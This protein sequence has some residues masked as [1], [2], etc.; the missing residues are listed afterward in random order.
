MNYRGPGFLAVVRSGSS[1]TPTPFSSATCLCFSVFLCVASRAYWRNKGGGRGVKSYDCE[2]AWSSIH[3]STLNTFH[4][5]AF[6]QLFYVSLANVIRLDS[7]FNRREA[8]CLSIWLSVCLSCMSVWPTDRALHY[9]FLSTG[10][11][12]AFFEVSRPAGG[13]KEMSSTV[14]WL[15]NS[16]QMR[17]MGAGSQP[18]NTAVHMEPK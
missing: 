16:A 4:P 8:G 5:S 11:I 10:A 7:H 12:Q 17:G 18:M 14:S 6:R 13:H 1:P 9:I 15:T 2:E 3:H